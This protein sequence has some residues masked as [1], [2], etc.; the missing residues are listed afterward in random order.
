MKNLCR[1][2]KHW[3]IGKCYKSTNDYPEDLPPKDWY[4]DGVCTRL[5]WGIHIATYGG[6]EGSGVD[7]IETDA[8][9]GCVLF[10]AKE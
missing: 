3:T 6:W 9:F 8:N 2:C 5:G 10:E 7:Y 1:N 4:I